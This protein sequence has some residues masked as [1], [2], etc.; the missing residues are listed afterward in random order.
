MSDDYGLK[1]E[2]RKNLNNE[3]QNNGQNEMEYNR[4]GG[5]GPSTFYSIRTTSFSRQ[6]YSDPNNP[7]KMICKESN[8]S[9]GF[10]PFEKEKNYNKSRENVY[11]KEFPSDDGAKLGEEPSFFQK[12]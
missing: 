6:C 9:S 10:N 11:T 1:F 12:M 7:G 3:G 2:N 4:G 8:N 5:G